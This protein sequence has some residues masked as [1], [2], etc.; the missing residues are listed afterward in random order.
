MLHSQAGQSVKL[1]LSS[2]HHYLR[3]KLQN[4]KDMA[5]A[6]WSQLIDSTAGRCAVAKWFL[7]D[8]NKKWN[9]DTDQNEEDAGLFSCVNDTAK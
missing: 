4:S 2:T 8:K 5:N 3:A 7:K 9:K 6:N 1:Q